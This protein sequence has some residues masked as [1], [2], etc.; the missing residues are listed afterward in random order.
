MTG[1]RLTLAQQR[2]RFGGLTLAEAMELRDKALAT[3]SP[4]T[5]AAGRKAWQALA[6]E[7][8]DHKGQPWQWPRHPEAVRFHLIRLLA[9][10][11]AID[12][13]VAQARTYAMENDPC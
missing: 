4:E 13:A 10:G 7:A 6:D 3:L 8:R 9:E 5:I 2:A 12:D 1:S 11:V